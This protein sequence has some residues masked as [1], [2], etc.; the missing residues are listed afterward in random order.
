M[1]EG[2]LVDLTLPTL[3][4]ALT[5]ECSTAILRL[6]NGTEQGSLYFCEGALVHASSGEAVGDEAV[7]AVLGWSDGRFRIMR[8]TDQQPRTITHRIS[9]FLASGDLSSSSSNASQL[10]EQPEGSPDERLL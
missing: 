1:V 7:L 8:D 10:S 3:L 9:E 5:K 2:D 6:Q 4:L